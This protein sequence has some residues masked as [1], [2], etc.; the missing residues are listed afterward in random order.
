MSAAEPPADDIEAVFWDVGG[1]LLDT[2]SVRAGHEAF[3]D[4]LVAAHDL[5][6]P[7]AVLSTWRRAVGDYF[8][9]RDGTEF[10][11]ARDAYH[12]AVEAVVG[13]PVPRSDWQPRFRGSMA[14]H[15]RPNAG[16]TTV[17][18]RLA[19]TGRHQGIVSDADTAE[20][21][22]I[23]EQLGVSTFV[24]AVTTSEDVGRTKP[25]PAVFETAL[26]RAGVDA[27][28]A[29][30]VGD[31]YEH[32]MAGAARLGIRTVA[33]GCEHGPAVT[34]RIDDLPE[35]LALLGIDR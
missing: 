6:S 18:E 14:D 29:L 33:F 13:R 30:M 17:V 31:R 35:L 9:E 11:P 23:L 24:D 20:C 32:D 25:D 34:H 2:D 22:F 10:R 1:V 5:G 3:V 7:D 16:A 27:S 28:R 15:V 8:R 4:W 12:R 26:E 21:R 19:A